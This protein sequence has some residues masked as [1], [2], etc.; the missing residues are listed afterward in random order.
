[1]K[2]TGVGVLLVCVFFCLL[3]I[4]VGCEAE[5]QTYS[6]TFDP[7]GGSAV[8]SIVVLENTSATKPA[9]PARQGFAFAGWHAGS[10]SGSEWDFTTPITK[11][12]KLYAKWIAIHTVTFDSQGSSINADPTTKTVTG[13][14]TAIDALPKAPK[15]DGYTFEGWFTAEEGGG[16]V[17]TADTVVTGDMTVYA[18]WEAIE[19]RLSFDANDGSGSIADELVKTDET[20]SLPSY[21]T[22][23]KPEIFNTVGDV[24]YVFAGWATTSTGK[25]EYDD[26]SDFVM[27]PSDQTLY[28]K[29]G[30]TR[31]ELQQRIT[32]KKD[33]TKV[34]TSLVADMS[35]LFSGD[36]SFN[37][38]ISGWDVSGARNMEGMFYWKDSFNQDLTG[39]DVSN[40][41]NMSS[42]FRKTN[43]FNGDIS[44]WD[45][46]NV[47]DMSL[48]FLEARV[49]N[50]NL[51]EWDVSSVTDMSSMFEDAW[52]FD[53]DISK[54]D[55]SSV[56]DMN[57]MFYDA[58]DF[59]QDLPNWDVSSVMDME[60]MFNDANDFNGDISKWDVSSVENMDSMFEDAIAFNGDI[61][62]W[63]SKT[64]KPVD[65]YSITDM[66]K[67]FY[68]AS[69]FNQ[70]L[71]EWDVSSVINFIDFDTNSALSSDHLP[72]FM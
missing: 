16:T 42:M 2:R 67:M 39:W 14:E 47:T 31:A 38:D 44:D 11:D 68:G 45:V 65:G 23:S 24:G 59:N 32:D 61:S 30:I 50:Q 55:V 21:S 5:L 52:E 28:A 71:S 35:Y 48:M 41:T 69:S 57:S 56:T 43:V 13:P 33:V 63:F 51:S 25:A 18:Q 22:L 6:I 34:D 3:I 70:D 37:Q 27:G 29:W 66:R 40:V 64:D 26:L 49:F 19:N 36:R 1:M 17:F 54:W 12:L 9:D 20:I 46:S 53:Q 7:E 60:D 10:S 15:R 72:N 58:N 8:G 62:T 4:L